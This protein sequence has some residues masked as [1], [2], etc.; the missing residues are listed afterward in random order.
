MPSASGVVSF[1]LGQ[2]RAFGVLGRR[3]FFSVESQGACF[4]FLLFRASPVA[5]GCSQARG[6]IGAAAAGLQHSHSQLQ[7]RAACAI[8]TPA[9]SNAG[10]STH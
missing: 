10:S 8:Y 9:H 1:R 6:R 3:A 2:G 4:F 7:I 5:Y